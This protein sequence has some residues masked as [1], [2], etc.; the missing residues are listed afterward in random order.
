MDIQIDNKLLGRVVI[1]LFTKELPL[2][3]ENFRALCTGEMMNKAKNLTYTNRIFKYICKGEFLSGGAIVSANALGAQSI[4]GGRFKDENYWIKHDQKGL[5]TTCTNGPNSNS[6]EFFF[7][8]GPC[9]NMDEK[10]SVFGRVI[11]GYKE[12]LGQIEQVKVYDNGLPLVDI[13]VYK[14]GELVGDRKLKENQVTSLI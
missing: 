8:F 14:C 3:T 5:L 9:P 10:N 2:A 13:K 6:S 11:E 1:E 7:T 12:V 4:Y